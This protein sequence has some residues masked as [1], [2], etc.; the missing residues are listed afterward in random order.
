MKVNELIDSGAYIQI[1]S[2]ETFGSNE[3]GADRKSEL[4][5]RN[6]IPGK[7]VKFYVTLCCKNVDIELNFVSIH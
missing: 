3:D 4:V 1:F 5:T 2:E 6:A 7:L